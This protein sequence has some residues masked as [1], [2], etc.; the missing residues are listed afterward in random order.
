MGKMLISSHMHGNGD[1]ETRRKSTVR[2]KA[3]SKGLNIRIILIA[4]A[5]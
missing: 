3:S 4:S 2:G 1:R 5:L